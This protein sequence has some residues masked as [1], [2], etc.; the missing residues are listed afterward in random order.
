MRNAAA[1]VHRLWQQLP[2][3]PRQRAY[4]RLT[5]AF[6]PKAMTTPAT[7]KSWAPPYTVAGVLSAP[8]GLGE[9]ARLL[10]KGL[11]AL[12]EDVATIDLTA[13]LRQQPL[14]PIPGATAPKLGAGTLFLVVQP[15]NVGSAL[16]AIGVGL[17]KDK[18]RVGHWV[19]D[20]SELPEQW[21]A[22]RAYVHD[23]ATPS[24]FC[25]DI[26]QR[27]FGESI[28]LLPY[29]VAIDAPA[30]VL[31]HE[32]PFTFGAAFD[33]GSTA[34]RKNPMA[35]LNAFE[36]AFPAR[37]GKAR[38]SIKVRGEQADM[39]AFAEIERRVRA[40]GDDIQLMT[41]DMST[42]K[43]ESWWRTI[44]V[45][46]NLHR[47]EGFGLLIAEAMLREIPAI[48]TDWSA[49]TD[50][51]DASCGWPVAFDLVPVADPSGKYV[52][53]TSVWADA[54]VDEAASAMRQAVDQGRTAARTKGSAGAERLRA[55]FGVPQF[56]IWLKAGG[57]Q[58]AGGP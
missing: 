18:R 16:Q 26:F 15:P 2:P 57:P 40:Y 52:S 33:L 35:T 13:R 49:T 12:G 42:A 10:L 9:S 31:G 37:D 56:S 24:R 19:W 51:V 47:S 3:G 38:L 11:Q 54:R 1:I 46:V 5:L 14:V 4:E 25:A 23:I 21:F 22:S 53:D 29:P 58:R 43:L 27:A 45:F 30:P 41:G 36:Q 44:D 20:L 17:L 55:M 50:Y 6:A 48:L 8:T 7:P 28:S 39:T 34:A 32:G